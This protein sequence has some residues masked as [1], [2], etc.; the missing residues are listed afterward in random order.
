MYQKRNY[1]TILQV[2]IQLINYKLIVLKMF[3]IKPSIHYC[4]S[5][6]NDI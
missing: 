3:L 5:Y 4:M 6:D 1:D 2:T